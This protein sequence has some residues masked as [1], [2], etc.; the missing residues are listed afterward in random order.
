MLNIQIDNPELEQYLKQA[1]GEN[2]QSIARVFAEF[3]QQQRIKQDIGVSIE[4]LEAG[5]GVRRVVY[6]RF[7]YRIV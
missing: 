2:S 4:Q 5:E 7:I 6:K 1:Y 3:V